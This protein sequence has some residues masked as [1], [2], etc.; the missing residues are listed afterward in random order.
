MPIFNVRIQKCLVCISDNS[1][2]HIL[3]CIILLFI[4]THVDPEV[5]VEVDSRPPINFKEQ[6]GRLLLDHPDGIQLNELPILFKV[7][8]LH[9]YMEGVN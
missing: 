6:I 9:Q 2:I 7:T 1:C 8:I 4:C 5:F 3:V